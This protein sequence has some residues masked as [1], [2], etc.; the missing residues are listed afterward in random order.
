MTINRLLYARNP[1]VWDKKKTNYKKQ[2][3]K[4]IKLNEY[5]IYLLTNDLKDL[6]N[7]YGFRKFLSCFCIREINERTI[8]FKFL[9]DIKFDLNIEDKKKEIKKNFFLILF[10]LGKVVGNRKM[11]IKDT[12]IFIS[13][14]RNEKDKLIIS[15]SIINDL[16]KKVEYEKILKFIKENPRKW[17][18]IHNYNKY[19]KDRYDLNSD[20]DYINK[21]NSELTKI[22]VRN[23][24]DTI[25][26][27]LHRY[28]KSLKNP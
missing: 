27:S 5:I 13:I 28:R 10:E 4:L 12:D 9:N 22:G 17:N 18:I 7:F 25:E 8:K 16:P 1:D 2:I 21:V 19:L 23:K 20:S 15:E 3:E 11:L 24:Y 14:L 6:K 26:Q